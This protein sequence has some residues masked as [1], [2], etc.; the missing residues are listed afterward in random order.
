MEKDMALVTR[1]TSSVKDPTNTT[2]DRIPAEIAQGHVKSL[3]GT[4]EAVN[5]DS[6]GSLY[7]LGDIPSSARISPGSSFYTDAIAGMTGVKI[8]TLADDDCLTAAVDAH[9]GG[10]F[11][12]TGSVDIAN[13][14]LPF[15]KLQAGVAVDPGGSIP[16][17]AKLTAALTAGG[18]FTHD[19]GFKT[20]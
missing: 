8:G 6:I 19:I 2:Q 16:V 3:L 9:L 11:S 12:A 10:K 1:Y 4:L 17:Y 14:P 20:P 18:T 13:Y 7:Y 15:W 5:G